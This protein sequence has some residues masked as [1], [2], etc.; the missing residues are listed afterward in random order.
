MTEQ[1][2]NPYAAPILPPKKVETR[3]QSVRRIALRLLGSAFILVFGRIVYGVF[4]EW[5]DA[6]YVVDWLAVL[7]IVGIALS[8]VYTLGNG[9]EG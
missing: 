8:V 3:R 7:A 6:R 9:E 4:S 2:E 5:S 1:P